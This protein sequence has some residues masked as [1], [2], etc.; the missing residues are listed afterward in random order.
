MAEATTELDLKALQ[1][2]RECVAVQRYCPSVREVA[3]ATERST[4]ATHARLVKLRRDGLLEWERGATRTLR[5]TTKGLQSIYRVAWETKRHERL[6]YSLATADELNRVTWERV[7]ARLT[8]KDQGEIFRELFPD[9]RAGFR[10]TFG[11]TRKLIEAF[12]GR[13]KAPLQGPERVI[14]V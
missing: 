2:I 5:L 10:M 7:S 8:L 6:R 14:G 4:T 13:S 11:M 3:K 12:R 9:L 1:A